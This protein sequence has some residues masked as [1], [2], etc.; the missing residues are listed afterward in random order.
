MA[1][2]S[3]FLSAALDRLDFRRLRIGRPATHDDSQAMP[4]MENLI[5]A[6]AAFG[7]KCAATLMVIRVR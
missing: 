7:N 2:I 5:A 3:F 6:V 4:Y 1:F